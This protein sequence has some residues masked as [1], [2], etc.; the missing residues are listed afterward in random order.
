MNKA[1]FKNAKDPL[2]KGIMYGTV[3]FLCIL[4]IFQYFITQSLNTDDIL[5]H[6]TI[7]LTNLLII[8]IAEGTRYSID[9]E[10][11]RY[12]SSFLFGKIP[13]KNITKI[14]VGTTMW[15][16]FRPAT[17]RNGIII[18]YNKNKKIYISPESNTAFTETLKKVKKDLIIE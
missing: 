12:Q 4:S 2:F 10:F 7:F 3:A 11:I 16:G 13:L 14:K 9:K 6:L 5:G 17:S 1:Y 8:W 18:Y 15:V